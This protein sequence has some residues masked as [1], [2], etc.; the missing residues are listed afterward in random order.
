MKKLCTLC[1]WYK[2]SRAWKSHMVKVH[3]WRYYDGVN[4]EP[5]K[6]ED[7]EEQL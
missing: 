6:F 7:M 5:P 4:P 3:G 2:S 1:G